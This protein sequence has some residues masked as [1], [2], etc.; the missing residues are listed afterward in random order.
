MLKS[1]FFTTCARN[2]SSKHQFPNT[3]GNMSG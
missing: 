2:S 3:L 1:N